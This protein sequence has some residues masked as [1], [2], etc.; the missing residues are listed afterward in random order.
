MTVLTAYDSGRRRING[1]YYYVETFGDSAAPRLAGVSP[2][3]LSASR[4][5]SLASQRS[6]GAAPRPVMLLLHGFTGST[7]TWNRL[8]SS[9]S[10]VARPIAIDQL[11]HGQ[12]DAPA[13]SARYAA[14]PCVDDIA[15]LL[16]VLEVDR[17]IILGYSMGGRL[18]LHFAHCHPDRLLALVLE[19]A[20]PGIQTA[21]ERTAR[22]ASDEKLAQ[23]VER[24]G[25]AAFVNR[26]EKLPLF[27]SLARLPEE[28]RVA[29]RAQ[30]LSNRPRGLAGS[31][32]GFGAAVPA[33]LFDSLPNLTTPTQIIVGG[34]DTKYTEL[35]HDMAARLPNARLDVVPDAG[36]NVH[37][38]RPDQFAAILRRFILD[39]FARPKSPS[40][41]HL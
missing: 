37:L 2:R 30:R 26:W 5:T 16:D 34:L 22:M 33:P 12:S 14:E 17:A 4:R 41:N 18:A 28:M 15:T 31:L 1:F 36:H 35:G 27:D 21:D 40:P 32:R 6:A 23:I 29:L 9:V 25:I 24:E 20:A 7:V 13:D 38:E 8:A 11:G 3:S 19:S 39:R 10:H